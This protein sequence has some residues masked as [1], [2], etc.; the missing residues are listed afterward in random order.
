DYRDRG[1]RRPRDDRDRDRDGG[2]RPRPRP[3]NAS[4]GW[5]IALV[6]VGIVGLA[7]ITPCLL[8]APFVKVQNGVQQQNQQPWPK[9]RAGPGQPRWR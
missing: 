8:L 3:S 7:V 5:I 2:P 6:V 9:P 4:T 1:R